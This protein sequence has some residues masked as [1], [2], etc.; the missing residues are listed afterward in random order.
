[1]PI[2]ATGWREGPMQSNGRKPS[3]LI[4]DASVADQ[5]TTTL[6]KS[7]AVTTAKAQGPM[8]EH[9]IISV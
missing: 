6:T 2:S 8:I 3:R 4:I 5:K 1:M 9:W 7:D